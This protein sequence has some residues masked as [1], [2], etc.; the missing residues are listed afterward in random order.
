MFAVLMAAA[1]VLV[2]YHRYSR[3]LRWFALSLVA[4]VLVLG[5]VHVD[6][7]AVAARPSFHVF[8]LTP[9]T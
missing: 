2:P 9:R 6:W 7:S 4:Y 8:A 5:V 1:E 3:V